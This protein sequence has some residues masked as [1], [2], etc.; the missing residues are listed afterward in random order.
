MMYVINVKQ[1]T[2]HQGPLL[3]I[4]SMQ[5]ENFAIEQITMREMGKFPNK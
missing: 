2:F 1:D 3:A 4:K 5:R